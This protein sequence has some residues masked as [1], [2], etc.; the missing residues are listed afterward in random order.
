MVSSTQPNRVIPTRVLIISDT[1][2]SLPYDSDEQEATELPFHKPLPPADVLIHCG[3]LTSTGRLREHQRALELIAGVDA[4]PKI[5][6]PGNHDITL[7]GSTTLSTVETTTGAGNRLT[8]LRTSMRSR[9]S[10]QV[11][12]L[13]TQ[14]FDTSSKA[15][16]TLRSTTARG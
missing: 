4:D 13:E 14:G 3:D 15:S 9:I 12:R 5:I 2:S 6:I 1:H 16:R 10:T 8:I 7:I 11:L